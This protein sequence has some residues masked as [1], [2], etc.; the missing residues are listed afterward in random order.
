MLSI[1]PS[2]A[3][4]SYQERFRRAVAAEIADLKARGFSPVQV[5]EGYLV[6]LQPDG[7]CRRLFK[8]RPFAS[9]EDAAAVAARRP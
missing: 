3:G 5:R 9:G 8:A 7:Q 6:A 2:P 1:A 4:Q